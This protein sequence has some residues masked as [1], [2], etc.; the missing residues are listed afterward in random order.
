MEYDRLM[1]LEGAP[2]ADPA[3]PL[4]DLL[5]RGLEAKPDDS[6]L[7]SIVRSLTWREL[8]QASA[9]LAGGYM[10]LGL[11]PG[12][13]V[14]SLMPN[15]IDLIVHY[16]ACFRAGLVATPLN[17]RYTHREID[18]AL[19]VS[20]AR[21]L[22]AH[23]EREEDVRTSRLVSALPFGVIGYRDQEADGGDEVSWPHSF[24]TLLGSEPLVSDPSPPVTNPAA[25]FFTS[26]STGPA[27]GVTHTRESLRW[28]LASAAAAFE[29]DASDR[30]MPASSMSHLRLVPVEP[31]HAVGRRSGHRRPDD[32]QPR[33]AA[34]PAHLPAHRP[35]HDPRRADGAG[36]RPRSRPE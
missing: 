17:Y 29:L 4:N 19:E 9:A 8:E 18:H 31:H 28:M 30:F 25:I 35:G 5:T 11:E 14:A 16:L 10:N 3:P 34:A 1:Q 21:V 7:V 27:K 33:A 22:L 2:L 6:A 15:R 13:R 20:E 26:G 12:D 24:S 23:V 32:R 36:A